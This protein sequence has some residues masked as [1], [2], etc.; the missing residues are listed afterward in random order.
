MPVITTCRVWTTD[1]VEGLLW[2]LVMASCAQFK[3][4]LIRVPLYQS[5]VRYAREPIGS[6]VWQT[7][8]ETQQLGKGDCEDLVAWRVAEL[9]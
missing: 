9:R 4:G 1:Q 2:G 8:L 6:E 7:A 3:R 5:G